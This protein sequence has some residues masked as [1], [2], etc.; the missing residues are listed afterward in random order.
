MSPT[1]KELS[2]SYPTLQGLCSTNHRAG[3]FSNLPC[4]W[5]S[6]VWADCQATDRKWAQIRVLGLEVNHHIPPQSQFPLQKQ[7]HHHGVRFQRA[8]KCIV[9]DPHAWLPK[10]AYW[11]RFHCWYH[12][13]KMDFHTM[14]AIIK[15]AFHGD[16]FSIV[17]RIPYKS[18]VMKSFNSLRP[19]DAT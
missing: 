9:F 5:L 1:E 8:L 18:C 12:P 4:G 7:L 14:A 2:F 11:Q 19:I 13:C 16:L 3:Y 10:P 6:I 15:T 17:T